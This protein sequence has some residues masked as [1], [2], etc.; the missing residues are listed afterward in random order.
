MHYAMRHVLWGGVVGLRED[1]CFSVN[2]TG[3][4]FIF[5]FFNGEIKSKISR[6]SISQITFASDT[7][8]EAVFLAM[9][10]K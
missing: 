1:F 10:V 8:R 9:F 3:L 6:S 5:F 7:D 4:S 2:F